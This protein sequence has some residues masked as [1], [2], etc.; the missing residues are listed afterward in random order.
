MVGKRR[1]SSASCEIDDWAGEKVFV[2]F[3][4]ASLKAAEGFEI[5]YL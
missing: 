4:F 1:R 5:S 2:C 3:Q